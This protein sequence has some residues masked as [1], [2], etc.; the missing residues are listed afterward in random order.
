MNDM[1]YPIVSAKNLKKCYKTSAMHTQALNNISLEIKKGEFVALTGRSGCG[2]STLLSVLGLLMKFDTGELTFDGK[3]ISDYSTSQLRRLRRTKL[4]FVFQSFNLISEETVLENAALPLKLNGVS[5]EERH[6]RARHALKELGIDHRAEHYPAQISGGQQQRVA[7]A[8]A[9]IHNPILI[10]ADEPTGNLDPE[11]GAKIIS[12][13]RRLSQRGTTIL[14][15]T[16][17]PVD[18]KK[19]DRIIKMEA[20]EIVG[21]E[22]MPAFLIPTNGF[23]EQA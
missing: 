15:V 5:K 13:L 18:V 21:E 7:I 12:E 16:H 9:I 2:K 4:G 6:I 22:V 3:E 10:L 8:R 20:G 14:M 19:A 11:T 1:N 17:S 23:E